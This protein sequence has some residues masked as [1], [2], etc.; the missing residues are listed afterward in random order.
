MARSHTMTPARRA[1]LKKAQA[2]SARKRRGK[3]KG[4]L[5]VANRKYDGR[6]RTRN[7]IVRYGLIGAGGALAAAAAY[8]IGSSRTKKKYVFSEARIRAISRAQGKS[9]E[10]RRNTR[11]N[12]IMSSSDKIKRALNNPNHVW[13]L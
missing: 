6:N 10:R 8:R 12:K 13:Q 5:A 2:A 1:A 3:G 4:K 11:Q 7:K 9:Q